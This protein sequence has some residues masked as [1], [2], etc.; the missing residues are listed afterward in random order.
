MYLHVAWHMVCILRAQP[1]G[2]KIITLP[3]F[4]VQ[5]QHRTREIEGLDPRDR[6]KVWV[7]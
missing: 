6:G 1:L 3:V 4:S 2:R 7:P 5:V